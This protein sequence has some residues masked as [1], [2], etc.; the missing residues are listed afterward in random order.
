MMILSGADL[1]SKH[2]RRSAGLMPNLSL[3]Y[4]CH[5]NATPEDVVDLPVQRFRHDGRFGLRNAHSKEA[6]PR[7][8][9]PRRTP[10]M[11]SI[12]HGVRAGALCMQ[13]LARRM[14]MHAAAGVAIA[15]RFI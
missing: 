1:A 8:N 13:L 14:M 12:D 9:G 11:G 15:A 6:T 5:W 10:R 4:P 2:S 3:S 7:R